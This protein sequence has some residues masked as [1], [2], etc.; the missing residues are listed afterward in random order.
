[1]DDLFPLSDYYRCFYTSE[2]TGLLL[3]GFRDLELGP[4]MSCPQQEVA[5][6]CLPTAKGFLPTNSRDVYSSETKGWILLFKGARCSSMASLGQPSKPSK[7]RLA[8]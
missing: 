1:M 6:D 4:P 8:W 7:V 3:A 2:I 5:K